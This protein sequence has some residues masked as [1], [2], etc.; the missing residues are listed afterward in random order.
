MDNKKR[1]GMEIVKQLPSYDYVVNLYEMI[2]HH[3]PSMDFN[4]YKKKE[5]DYD[6]VIEL[7][8]KGVIASSIGNDS[9]A[10]SYYKEAIDQ[11]IFMHNHKNRYA[12]Y[13]FFNMANCLMRLNEFEQAFTYYKEAIKYIETQKNEHRC[14]WNLHIAKRNIAERDQRM[15]LM[16]F[17]IYPET[18]NL[19]ILSN[20]KIAMNQ[21]DIESWLDRGLALL[22]L[23]KWDQAIHAFNQVLLL[24]KYCYESWY[25]KD[26]A[27]VSLRNQQANN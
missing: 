26:Y 4:D 13:I 6:G 10:I 5:V 15:N 17:P 7:F 25:L 3:I 21:T 22:A 27:Y 14:N 16:K 20:E 24:D 8:N 2:G 11:H 23:S 19:L 12:E 1:V 18:E 9:K